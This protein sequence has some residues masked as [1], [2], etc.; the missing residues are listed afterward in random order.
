MDE[1]P[2]ISIQILNQSLGDAEFCRSGS[3]IRPHLVLLGQNRLLRQH[4]QQ[5]RFAQAVLNNSVLQTVETNHRHPAA[6][7]KPGRGQ[8]NELLKD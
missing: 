8:V 1:N 2:S 4:L 5:L 3:R 7:L 6:G